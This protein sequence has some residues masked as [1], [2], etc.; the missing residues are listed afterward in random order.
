MS[1][2]QSGRTRK[3][4]RAV[5]SLTDEQVQH[6]RN[7]DRKAQRAFR[8]RT[9]DCITNLEGQFVQLQETCSQLRETCAQKDRALDSV[10]G[11]NRALLSCLTGIS[12]LISETLSQARDEESIEARGDEN[13]SNEAHTEQSERTATQTEAPESRQTPTQNEASLQPTEIEPQPTEPVSDHQPIHTPDQPPTTH[14][15]VQTPDQAPPASSDEAI[16]SHTEHVSDQYAFYADDT[17]YHVASSHP[18]LPSPPSTNNHP[19][20]PYMHDCSVSQAGAASSTMAHSETSGEFPTPCSAM[21][22]PHHYVGPAAVFTVLPSHGPSTCPLDQ[23]LLDFLSSRREMVSNGAMV[24]SVI[25]PQKP[26]VRG[27]VDTEQGDSVHPVSGI[28]SRVLST[29]PSVQLAEKLAF[30]FL[31]CHT[32]RWQIYPAKESYLA[33]PSWLRPTVTQITVPHAAWID[34]I[35]W[36]GVRDIL[37]ENPD[38]YPFQLFSDYYSQ[39]VTVNWKFDGLDAVSNLDGEGVLHSIFEKHIRNL[40]NWTVSREFEARFPSMTTAIYSRD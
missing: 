37:I 40:K 4:S 22:D 12:D 33:M 9:K 36:P 13:Q 14:Q 35:P 30:F 10:R 11:Q 21:I 23:I 38:E 17:T 28:M 18:G 15:P 31:M 39:N 19:R 16:P 1:D 7:V 32:M 6:K 34:N 27:L 3:R 5:S 26:A 8:Q 25:G 29:F 20:N 24:D 2:S